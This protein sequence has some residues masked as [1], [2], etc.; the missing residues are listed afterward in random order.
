MRMGVN[1]FQG[2]AFI[3]YGFLYVSF[4]PNASFGNCCDD[5][6]ST[7]NQKANRSSLT[8]RIPPLRLRMRLICT[9]MYV[10]IFARVTVRTLQRKIG[11]NLTYWN[12]KL[13]WELISLLFLHRSYYWVKFIGLSTTAIIKSKHKRVSHIGDDVEISQKSE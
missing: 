7:K 4:D 13:Y 3:L 9:F 2:S 1:G 8:E 10:C 11:S 12:C 5:T 6:G